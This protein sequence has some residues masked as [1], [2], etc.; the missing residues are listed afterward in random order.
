MGAGGCSAVGMLAVR[1]V[2]VAEPESMALARVEAWLRGVGSMTFV[3]LGS[4]DEGSEGGSWG[5]RGVS[6]IA[7]GGR[8]EARGVVSRGGERAMDPDAF[9][10]GVAATRARARLI[11][12]LAGERVSPAAASPCL[13]LSRTL[14]LISTAARLGY[15]P[16]HHCTILRRAAAGTT[17][18]L[19][20]R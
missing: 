12:W 3:R 7:C 19:G 4:G 14:A 17:D 11:G 20:F 2:G 10:G 1:G 5:G 16:V 13:H 18:D 8:L 9:F 6:D 15:S